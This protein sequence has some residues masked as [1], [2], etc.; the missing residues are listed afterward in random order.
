LYRL[1]ATLHSGTLAADQ[2]SQASI[3]SLNTTIGLRSIDWSG[4]HFKL[5]GKEV[6]VRGFSH[7]SD[8]GAV[9]G[10]VADRINVFRANALRSVGGNW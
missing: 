9:G 4:K 7:H 2:L 6:H 1:C 10:A 8:F 5:N 3:D